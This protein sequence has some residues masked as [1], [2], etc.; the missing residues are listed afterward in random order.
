MS[1]LVLPLL[2][3]A[4]APEE[5]EARAARLVSLEFERTGRSVPRPDQALNR[6]ARELA[7]ESL[8]SSPAD[9]A[10][11]IV[12]TEAVSRAG[13]FDP[14]PRTLVIRGSPREEPLRSLAARKDLPSEAA[15]HF[16]LGAAVEGERA[17]VV[18][19]LAQRK[20]ALSPFPRS[21]APTRA[22]QKLCGEVLEPLSRA[23][24]YVTRPSG[25]VEK[26]LPSPLPRFCLP[27][28]FTQA[29]Q[30]LIEV[31]GMGPRGP[32]VAALFLVQVGSPDR[33][34][35]HQGGSEPSTVEAARTEVLQRINALRAG[36]GL[37]PLRSDPRLDGV[38]Q[39]YAEEMAQQGYFSHLSPDGS[40]LR[41]RL[42]RASYAYER[43]GENLGLAAGPL[44]AHFAIEHSPGHRRN[45]IDPGYALL[46]L[47]IARRSTADRDEVILTQVLATP[48]LPG[49]DTVEEAYRALDSRRA[50]LGLKP[51][52]RNEE[53]E[54]IALEHLKKA[55]ELDEPRTQ[56][57]GREVQERVFE[58]LEQAT[59]AAV[60][61]FIA[62]RPTLI[63][64]SKN[65]ADPRHHYVGLAALRTDSRKY[66][67]GNYWVVLIYA[68]RR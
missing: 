43:A 8:T 11:L 1:A 53:L 58:A 49:G 15:S 63:T 4:L 47:G 50:Q 56:L 13:G 52:A 33:R 26:F 59:S 27:L 39:A 14:S 44:A 9:A 18:L 12:L 46:G 65:L 28:A 21:L 38:A 30:H 48:A 35:E 2:L 32:E 19:L 22:A 40:D 23:E 67:K 16:G 37:S 31:L 3:A 62:E 64:D 51:L 45:L 24:I 57:P 25:Q 20:A 36:V 5:L 29:G 10:D 55:I 6:A 17:A 42:K 54:R 60:E 34:A 61:L 68:A 41:A 7:Q 66:G